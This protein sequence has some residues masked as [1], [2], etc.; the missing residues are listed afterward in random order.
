M[1]ITEY[2]KYLKLQAHKFLVISLP[3]KIR[4]FKKKPKIRDFS[5]RDCLI[6]S[7][8]PRLKL[9]FSLYPESERESVTPPSNTVRKGFIETS[10]N[11]YV[12]PSK[13]S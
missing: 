11:R 2:M 13:L 5:F 7:K 10:R 3:L 4:G 8:T 9:R 6:R 12:T 1:K